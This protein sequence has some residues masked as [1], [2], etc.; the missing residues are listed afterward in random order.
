[1]YLLEGLALLAGIPVVLLLAGYWIAAR[2]D[3]ISAAER[4]AVALLAGL[5]TLLLV[6]AI[7]NY[8]RPLGGVWAFLC[9][10]PC[11]FSPADGKVRR[12]LWRDLADLLVN[13]R[14]RMLGYGAAAVVYLGLLLWPLLSNRDLVFY[15]GTSNHDS[16]FWITLA[17]HLKRHTYM[18]APVI[19]ATR[20]LTNAAVAI[21]GLEPAWGRMGAEGLL[22]L[23]STIVGAAPLKIYVYAT[24]SLYFLWIAGAYLVLKTF[25][26]DHLGG[27]AAAG[28][29]LAQPIFIFFYSNAN[30]P[31]LIGVLAA[32]LLV[33][34]LARL[35]AR[36]PPV[37]EAVAWSGL[38]M[39]STH[40]LLCSYPEMVPF[41]LLPCGLFWL[42][43]VAR[44]QWTMGWMAAGAILAGFAVNWVTSVRAIHG[45]LT[46][47]AA[48]RAD[49][50]WGDLFR[51][52][53]PAEFV[54][55][56]T[57]LI[58]SASTFLNVWLGAP[59][60]LFIVF[61]LVLMLRRARDPLGLGMALA[62][63]A[64][65]LTYTA[66]TGFVYGWQ[67]T[68]QF[69]GIIIGALFP[70]GGL[71]VLQQVWREAAPGLRR[72]AAA[73]GISVL[74]LY[75]G[76][77]TYEGA[78]STYSWARAK[79]IQR[80]VFDLRDSG[81]K[82]LNGGRMLVIAESFRM[83]FFDGMWAAYCL[84][85]ADL[86]YSARGHEAGGYLRASV[87]TYRPGDQPPPDAIYV[88][89]AWADSIDA[90]SDRLIDGKTCA[91][92][93]ATNHVLGLEGFHPENGVPDGMSPHATLTL[94]PHTDSW[95][96]LVLAPRPGIPLASPVVAVAC[97]HST[98][99]KPAFQTR[100]EGAPPW[101][102]AVPLQA[103]IDN[104]I[105]IDVTIATP[106]SG[107]PPVRIEQ[108]RITNQP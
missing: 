23:T 84:P 68:I 77:A 47:F 20:P 12:R 31:N 49:A 46:S 18:E 72:H 85:H 79:G 38:I 42:R 1:M 32:T 103:A 26:A 11:V 64:L 19:S 33:V 36:R 93:R 35:L 59:L 25:V 94:R 27:V 70:A 48:A 107:K 56:L 106:A 67:K 28:L 81:V 16:F 29:F 54:P 39:L 80:E 45:F 9:L 101:R 17:D 74:V 104:R 57:T 41:V 50:Q 65:L 61:L 87:L 55:A 52:L 97:R 99:E 14:G 69:G 51:A 76:Y 58:V 7:V 13:R 10:L 5:S 102:L 63:S 44:R 40:A 37:G 3:D 98:G 96:H 60:S 22:A 8:F 75:Y 53:S 91:V 34:A 88:S 90:N 4:L 15:D 95:L 2:L 21:I 108:L 78:H 86:I 71:I 66:G 6:I 92:L 89:R 30:L 62:G 82:E 105:E 43:G 73:A 83:A 24:A 100:L